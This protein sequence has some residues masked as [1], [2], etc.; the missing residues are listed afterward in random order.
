MS[1]N[2]YNDLFAGNLDEIWN[3][4]PGKLVLF[5]YIKRNYLDT[6]I[7]LIDI[8]CGSGY[9]ANRIKLLNEN[10]QIFGFDYSEEAIKKA[11]DSYGDVIFFTEDVHN[12]DW[13]NRGPFDL[14]ISYGCFEH[15]EKP[16][17]ALKNLYN[18]L[19]DGGE[20]LLMIPTLGH[21]RNDRFD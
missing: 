17:V 18:S 8:G 9:F 16:S 7:K 3:E 2:F 15:F 1:R 21:Y 6:P 14:A 11:I 13:V 10:S 12:P 19:R 4:A 20:F 5:N